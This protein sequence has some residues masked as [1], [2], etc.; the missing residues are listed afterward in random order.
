MD[1]NNLKNRPLIQKMTFLDLYYLRDILR[2]YSEVNLLILG[3]QTSTSSFHNFLKLD[4][5]IFMIIFK[6]NKNV[7]YE[8]KALK[9]DLEEFYNFQKEFSMYL[10]SNSTQNDTLYKEE[11]TEF[12]T[13]RTTEIS[14]DLDVEPEANNFNYKNNFYRLYSENLGLNMIMNKYENSKNIETNFVNYFTETDEVKCEFKPKGETLYEC[15]QL[16]KIDM[17]HCTSTD[18]STL[19]DNCSNTDCKWNLRNLEQLK[20]LCPSK[21]KL[22]GFAGNTRVKLSWV[23]PYTKFPIESYYIIHESSKQGNEFNVCL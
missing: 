9:I 16:C 13:N 4:K 15:K 8:Y 11:T 5:P 19:C 6:S 22:R 20:A 17:P 12:L 14:L 21:V 18:C 1:V 3:I 23:K 7:N 2:D 10:N